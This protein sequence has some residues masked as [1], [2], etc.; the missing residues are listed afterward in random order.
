MLCSLIFS[1]LLLIVSK[2]PF[3]LR[4]FGLIGCSLFLLLS[5]R[6][7]FRCCP[8]C[9]PALG[10]ECL[11][12]FFP[13]LFLYAPLP[14]TSYI[15][16]SCNNY[17]HTIVPHCMYILSEN[18]VDIGVPSGNSIGFVFLPW[19]VIPINSRVIAKNIRFCIV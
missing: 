8:I 13:V 5:P 19:A 15:D 17:L 9:L 14:L 3:Y 4:L 16:F 7:A 11:S 18:H 1:L 12:Q 6:L 10:F 2:C